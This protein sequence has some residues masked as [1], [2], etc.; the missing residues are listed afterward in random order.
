[1][2]ISQ[3]KDEIIL[4]RF[5]VGTQV[6]VSGSLTVSVDKSL[7][8]SRYRGVEL[9]EVLSRDIVVVLILITIH[10]TT[11]E[12]SERHFVQSVVG[13]DDKH[14]VVDICLRVTSSD[15]RSALYVITGDHTGIN[16]G[17]SVI[18]AFHI[19][20][21]EPCNNQSNQRKDCEIPPNA[22]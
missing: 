4:G 16:S 7:N 14:K 13:G 11:C 12:E 21:Q 3:S 19:P 20:C 18:L 10:H 15:T 9:L 5:L 22:V 6:G 8:L 17:V 1:M 2:I